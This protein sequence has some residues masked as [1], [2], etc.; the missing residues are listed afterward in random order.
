LNVEVTPGVEVDEIAVEPAGPVPL[1][2]GE[3]YALHV[4]G[5]KDGK[6]VGDI[7]SLAI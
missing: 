3:T 2:P 5:Y 1:R 7:T 4:I 6:S